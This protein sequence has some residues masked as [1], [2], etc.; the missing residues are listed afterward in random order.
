MAQ[1]LHAVSTRMKN[2]AGISFPVCY[3]TATL[4][5]MDKTGLPMTSDH[6]QVTCKR[7]IK[8]LTRNQFA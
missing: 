8:A 5:D 7:C 3:R 6:K 2:N 1:K 4:L